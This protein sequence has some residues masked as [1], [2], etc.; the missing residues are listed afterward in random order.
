MESMP[1]LKQLGARMTLYVLTL[2]DLALSVNVL[3]V[4][5]L[6]FTPPEIS[7]PPSS[8]SVPVTCTQA[9]YCLS[10][11]QLPEAGG[12]GPCPRPLLREQCVWL[13]VCLR[14]SV[15]SLSTVC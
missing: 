13:W 14:R 8:L 4:T 3:P 11:A 15:L 5:A 9:A 2:A 7:G 10:A 6:E 12:A 1:L